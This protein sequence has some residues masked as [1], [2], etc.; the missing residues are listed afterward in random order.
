MYLTRNQLVCNQ[1][2]DI[3]Q[4]RKAAVQERVTTSRPSAA[5]LTDQS[6]PV[7]L[8]LSRDSPSHKLQA[9]VYDILPLPKSDAR[10]VPRPFIIA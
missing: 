6:Q 1:L 9:V 2:I 3:V 8:V 5:P 10:S 7:E 4:E